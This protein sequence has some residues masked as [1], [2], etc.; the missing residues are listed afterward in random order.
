[1]NGKREAEWYNSRMN[2]DPLKDL[3]EIVSFIKDNMATR[4]EVSELRSEFNDF[5]I[6]VRA[7]FRELRREISDITKRLDALDSAVA[8]IRGYAKEIDT[9]RERLRAIERHIGISQTIAA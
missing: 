1:M 8:D 3:L 4:T 5:R 7:E 6:E 9:L 2:A